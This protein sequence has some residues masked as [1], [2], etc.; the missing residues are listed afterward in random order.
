M[1]GLR[2][3]LQISKI[4]TFSL[5]RSPSFVKMGDLGY[6]ILRKMLD[7]YLVSVARSRL[8]VK[9]MTLKRTII[10]RSHYCG[11]MKD[12]HLILTELFPYFIQ[13]CYR[14]SLLL[15]RGIEAFAIK[16]LVIGH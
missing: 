10:W 15:V 1:E 2:Q 14:P 11:Y 3:K 6:Q 9:Q 8:K 12:P 16:T 7:I 5:G 4:W 13:P